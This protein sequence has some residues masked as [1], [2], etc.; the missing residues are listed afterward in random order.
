MRC[1]LYS[2]SVCLSLRQIFRLSANSVITLLLTICLFCPVQLPGQSDSLAEIFSEAVPE[3]EEI[4]TLIEEWTTNPL[5]INSASR[6]ELETFAFL[7]PG[8]I[9]SILESRPFKTKSTLRPILGKQIYDLFAPF[10]VTRK[11]MP[12]FHL[13]AAVQTQTQL[14]MNDGFINGKYPG[15]PWALL[16]RL[17]LQYLPM[18]SVGILTQQDRGEVSWYD[19][20]SGFLQWTGRQK[21]GKIVLGSYQLQAAQGLVFS[22]PFAGGKGIF[23][24]QSMHNRGI[25]L[26]SML[27]AG[28]GS[29]FFGLGGQFLFTRLLTLT[30]FYSNTTRDAGI[31]A[32]R[33]VKL[34]SSGY[35][36]TREEM[37]RKDNVRE[38]SSGA[39]GVFSLPG[40]ISFGALLLHTRYAIEDNH[41]VT[42]AATVPDDNSQN[43][44]PGY[45]RCYSVFANGRL[46]GFSLS[47][48]LAANRLQ[49]ISQQ[50]I[51]SYDYRGNETA[52]KWWSVAK[53]YQSPF[54][55][56]FASSSSFPQARQ[57]VY[58]TTRIKPSEKFQL[59]LYWTAEKDLWRT[60]FYPLPL[61]QKEYSAQIIYYPDPAGQVQ[62]QYR[63]MQ[64]FPSP[65]PQLQVLSTCSRQYRIQIEKSYSTSIRI[66]CRMEKIKIPGPVPASGINFFNELCWQPAA[67]IQWVFHFSSF[68]ISDYPAH[69]Y[70]Y[71]KDIPGVFSSC[72]VYGRGYKWY[73]LLKW[74]PYTRMGIWL[75]YRF[76]YLDGASAIGSSADRINGDHKQEIRIQVEVEY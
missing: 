55:H 36:R 27:S 8:Q 62:F 53:N 71:E 61:N 31:T 66:R 64:R 52:I 43:Y 17:R 23:P 49:R 45:I 42:S 12:R 22:S 44:L 4:L 18:F 58:L 51:A 15:S 59:S 10:F 29:G 35:H 48:E 75:K 73:L 60:Y 50:Y 24:T 69:T 25:Q 74:L 6:A 14:E 68:Q 5:N 56:S 76:L 1:V 57:G 72:V 37:E 26:S 70:E 16:T 33:I 47:G 21:Q 38:T 28:E 2:I 39:G 20:A 41:P 65:V 40:F 11:V 67:A 34:E 7:S 54:G 19:H 63:C 3:Q 32:G 9:D 13:Q 46:A 30:L